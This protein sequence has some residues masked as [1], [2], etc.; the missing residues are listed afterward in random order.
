MKVLAGEDAAGVQLQRSGRFRFAN[1][2]SCIFVLWER[3]QNKWTS[4]ITNWIL[5]YQRSGGIGGALGFHRFNMLYVV[6]RSNFRNALR[7]KL[8]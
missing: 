6:I 3:K 8:G 4:E 1:E 2:I 7:N 5:E